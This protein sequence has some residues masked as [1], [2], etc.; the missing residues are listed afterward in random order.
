MAKKLYIFFADCLFYQPQSLRCVLLLWRELQ[1]SPAERSC[2][3]E[4]VEV[5][6]VALW[7]VVPAYLPHSAIYLYGDAVSRDRIVKTPHSGWVEA[8]LCDYLRPEV[9]PKQQAERIVLRLFLSRFARAPFSGCRHCHLSLLS[10]Y[11]LPTCRGYPLPHPRATS[12]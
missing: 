10:P 12:P 5:C 3:V 7:S 1:H 11:G 2:V 4:L 6:D 9:L 8:M